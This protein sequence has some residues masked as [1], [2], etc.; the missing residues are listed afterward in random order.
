MK[1]VSKDFFTLLI[2][3]AYAWS[4]KEGLNY[5]EVLF[6][7]TCL[8]V[9]LLGYSD[10]NRPSITNHDWVRIL[11][12]KPR[13]KKEQVDYFYGRYLS[14]EKSK[15]PPTPSVHGCFSFTYHA[16][17]N[18]FELHFVNADPK[19]NY[20]KD[21]VPIRL[22]ELKRMFEAMKNENHPDALVKIGT[23][24]LNLEAFKRLFP[25]EFTKRAVFLE[26]PLTQN[27]THWGQFLT[28]EGELKKDLAEQFIITVKTKKYDH[29]NKYFPLPALISIIEQRHFYTFYGV[30]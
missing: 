6:S 21:R 29:I 8:Y 19:G 17:K 13:S 26:T 7:N 24:Q 3:F 18:L 10:V 5:D 11:S 30:T 22:L 16:D 2:D 28:K 14:F 20:S 23:W 27:Y 25:P 1:L 4:K 15:G 12:S 9:R